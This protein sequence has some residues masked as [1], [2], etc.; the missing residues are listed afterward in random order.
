MKGLTVK[1]QWI[2]IKKME[3]C[4]YNCGLQFSFRC[5]FRSETHEYCNNNYVSCCI[6][7][8]PKKEL[9]EPTKQRHKRRVAFL[10]NRIK[11]IYHNCNASASF[12]RADAQNADDDDGQCMVKEAQAYECVAGWLKSLVKI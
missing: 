4:C 7:W 2:R 1:L 5:K 8:N 10:E 9:D 6:R 12:L 11:A 3:R